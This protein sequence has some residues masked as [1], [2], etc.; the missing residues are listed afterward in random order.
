VGPLSD[1][2]P[3]PDPG[4]PVPTAS[5]PPP[6]D[7]EREPASDLQPAARPYRPPPRRNGTAFITV[8]ALGVVVA[9]I[10]AI[11]LIELSSSGSVKSQLSSPTFLAGRAQDYAPLV[12]RAGPILLPDP[13]GRSRNVYLQHLGPDPTVG[14]ITILAVPPGEPARCVVT[15]EQ[16]TQLFRDPCTG[17]TYAPD[18]AGLVRYPTTVLPSRRIQVDL[19]DQLPSDYTVTTGTAPP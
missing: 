6:P 3:P 12:A 16:G 11:S 18:G 15:W 17:R 7:P 13:Q 5:D 9:V 2:P 4:P 8:A 10:V 14:W 19:R 1:P